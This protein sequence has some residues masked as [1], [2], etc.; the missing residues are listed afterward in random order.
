MER[1]PYRSWLERVTAEAGR[2]GKD[3][4]K[5]VRDAAASPAG[6]SV[7]RAVEQVKPRVTRAVDELRP[8]VKRV[9]EQVAPEVKK[10]AGEVVQGA[11]KALNDL[12]A[13]RR[14]ADDARAPEPVRAPEP[15][16]RENP[17]NVSP[18][19]DFSEMSASEASEDG[20]VEAEPAASRLT[21]AGDPEGEASP[22][23]DDAD[24]PV[25]PI[26]K[27]KSKKGSARRKPSAKKPRNS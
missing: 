5:L 8:E 19:V 4:E 17:P 12:M 10:V 7:K 3:V 1:P 20:A 11:S 13:A 24:T 15:P 25:E 2:L 21:P 14:A 26:R 9:Y 6:Q 18:D 22:T 27:P 23:G 16:R